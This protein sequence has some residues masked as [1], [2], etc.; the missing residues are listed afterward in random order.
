MSL[1]ADVQ[2]RYNAAKNMRTNFEREW[3]LNLAFVRNRQWVTYDRYSRRV[4]D[5]TPP[6]N[7]PRLTANIILPVVRTEFAKLTANKPSFRVTAI[8]ASQDDVVES[9]ICKQYLDFLWLTNNYS[10]QFQRALLW[11]LICGT[12]FVKTYYNKGAGPKV[13]VGEETYQLGD[14]EVDSCSPFEIYI[15]PFARSIEEASWVIHARVRSPEYVKHKWG[16][17]VPAGQV[18]SHYYSDGSLATNKNALGATTSAVPNVLVLEYWERPSPQYPNGR[19]SV[20]TTNQLFYEGDNPYA[21]ICP[22]PFVMMR[23]IPLPDVFYGDSVV[24]QLRQ[25]NVIYNKIR[26]DMI[27]NT[28]KLANPPLVAP[29]NALLKAPEFEPGEV[30]YYNP[31]IGGK[32][33]Q[34]KVEPYP[35]Q[36]M[37]M[38]MRIWQERDDI[39]GMSDVSRGTVPRGVRSA[40]ALAYLLEQDQTRIAVTAREWEAMVGYGMQNVLYLAREFYDTPRLIRVLGDNNSW[41]VK[42][43]KGADIPAD[44]DVKVE[45]SSTLPRSKVQ[46]QQFMLELWDRQI[47]TDPSKVMRLAEYGTEQEIYGDIELDTNQ[48]LRENNRMAEGTEAQVED[49]HNHQIHIAEHNR[50]RKTQAYDDLPEARKALFVQHVNAHRQFLQPPPAPIKG[51]EARSESIF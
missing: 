3:K 37:N 22:I 28:V 9:K 12:G 15:D 35:P 41:A 2:K 51:G 38:L 18:D 46:E 34:L 26:S 44:A 14:V 7:K 19:Y 33:D 5:W 17:S 39:A 47:L 48:A 16:V 23:H 45:E 13:T 29:V 36:S 1:L 43:F 50:F 11:A 30:I 21:G 40:S 20:G 49:F 4:V 8:T 24:S 27:E 6:N 42:L 32:I 10:K 31:L 25:I